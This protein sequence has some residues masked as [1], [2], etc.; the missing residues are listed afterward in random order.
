MQADF[1]RLGAQ[2]F[3]V[4]ILEENVYFSEVDRLEKVYIQIYDSIRNG[5]N[6][7]KGGANRNFYGLDKVDRIAVLKDGIRK[8]E[9]EKIDLKNS[10][11]EI[12]ISNL[13]DDLIEDCDIAIFKL[14]KLIIELESELNKATS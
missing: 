6:Q 1:N 12:G 10:S 14:R 4:E 3:A 11:M 2:N 5:Y 13:Y 9:T 7:T 8:W